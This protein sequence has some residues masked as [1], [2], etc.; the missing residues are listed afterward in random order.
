M[1]NIEM[2]N[3]GLILKPLDPE[4]YIFGSE[5]QLKGEILQPNGQ[6]IDFIPEAERQYRDSFETN[7]CTGFG[8]L[9]MLE[10][11]TLRKFGRALNFSDRFLN[12]LSG[13]DPKKG[14]YPKA[15]AETLRKKWSVYEHEWPFDESIKTVEDFYAEVPKRLQLLALGRGA[16]WSFGYDFITNTNDVNLMNALMYSPLCISVALMPGEDGMYYKPEGWQDSHW[17][18]LIGYKEGEYWLVYDS[19]PSH[20]DEST[21]IKKVKWDTKFQVAMRYTLDRQIV[22]ESPW[23]KFISWL[24]KYVFGTNN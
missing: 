6:W 11:L 24:E 5:T 19:Y 17:T 16:E 12:K 15:P 20:F 2:H 13:T 9:N 14:N 8:T 1:Q 21:H 23:Q 10:I 7:G 18:T 22:N 4:D 3:R